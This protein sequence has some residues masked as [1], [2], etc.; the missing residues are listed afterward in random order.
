MSKSTKSLRALLGLVD[1]V[2]YQNRSRISEMLPD[3]RQGAGVAGCDRAPDQDSFL[4]EVGE[5][6]RS[7]LSGSGVSAALGDLHSRFKPTGWGAA[8]DSWVS[9]EP[10]RPRAV[11]ELEAATGPETLADLGQK[12]GLSRAELLLRLNAALPEVVNRLTPNGRIPTDEEAQ[13]VF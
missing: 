8:A 4:S 13:A 1:F 5:M 9:A 12:T 2:G 10:N 6:F 3:A 7:G 11:S